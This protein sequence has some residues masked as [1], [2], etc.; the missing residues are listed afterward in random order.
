MLLEVA[1]KI[2]WAA[3]NVQSCCIEALLSFFMLFFACYFSSLLSFFYFNLRW[4]A[5]YLHHSQV[6]QVR[7][8]QFEADHSFVLLH[9]NNQRKKYYKIN[10]V[11]LIF[12]SCLFFIEYGHHKLALSQCTDQVLC[13]TSSSTLLTPV[14]SHVNVKFSL[15]LQR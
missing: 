5:I 3:W 14:Y 4:L 7:E 15:V 13:F 9:L 8:P 11:F 6:L 12:S 10:K 1:G 2:T